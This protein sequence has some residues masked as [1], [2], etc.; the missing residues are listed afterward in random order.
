MTDAPCSRPLSRLRGRWIR[1]VLPLAVAVTLLGGGGLAALETDTVG[2]YW[3]G[4]WWALSLMTTV[5]FTGGIPATLVGKL[6]SALLM[7]VGFAVLAMSTAAIASLFVR[8]DEL[9]EDQREWEF[10]RKALAEL[11]ALSARLARIEGRLAP[12]ERSITQPEARRPRD[13]AARRVSAQARA[14]DDG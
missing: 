9:P 11:E 6:L 1:A 14:S 10:E 4:V 13:A 7:V 2:S 5:G 12:V 3:D 8:E